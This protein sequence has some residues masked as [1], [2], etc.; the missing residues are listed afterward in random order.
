MTEDFQVIL[1]TASP[2]TQELVLKARQLILAK[3]PHA[4]ML[5]WPKQNVISYGAGPKKM[6]EHFVY[7]TVAKD[8]MNI[9]FYYGAELPD[10]THI[11]KGE[12]KLLKHVKITTTAQLDD[13]ELQKLIEKATHYLPRLAGHQT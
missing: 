1:S 8:H 12:G 4:F 10:P 5:A 2:S 6:S 9:G 7:L 11:L 13:P 3:Y